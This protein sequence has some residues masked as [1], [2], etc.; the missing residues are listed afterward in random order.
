MRVNIKDRRLII[1]I[2]IIFY[3]LWISFVVYPQGLRVQELQRELNEKRIKLERAQF[4]PIR[5]RQLDNAISQEKAIIE[6][7]KNRIY[8]YEIIANLLKD[9]EDISKK[10]NIEVL[11][12]SGPNKLE[13]RVS[14]NFTLKGSYL[15][16][17]PWAYEL[18][19][20]KTLNIT[21]LNAKIEN[22]EIVYSGILETTPFQEVKIGQ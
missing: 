17:T 13:D 12:I 10:Y 20:S 16:F 4:Y 14:F 3:V 5:E 21:Q 9:I 11:N 8:S 22:N 6:E 15:D 19:L 18:S 7:L 1:L 2:S